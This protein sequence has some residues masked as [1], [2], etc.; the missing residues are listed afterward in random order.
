MSHRNSKE[1]LTGLI[2]HGT[3]VKDER[4]IKDDFQ[5]FKPK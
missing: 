5:V 3:D 4:D 1:K 2:S